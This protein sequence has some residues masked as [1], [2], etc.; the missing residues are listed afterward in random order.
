[1]HK[2]KTLK[3]LLGLGLVVLA[4]M[5]VL[6]PLV[7][8]TT[9]TRSEQATGQPVYVTDSTDTTPPPGGGDAPFPPNPIPIPPPVP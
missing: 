9:P 1:M 6:A 7:A 4:V 2:T 3:R 5:G 8:A